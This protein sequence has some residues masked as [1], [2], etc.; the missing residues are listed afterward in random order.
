MQL[1]MFA[2]SRRRPALASF[3]LGGLLLAANVGAVPIQLGEVNM[4]R[5]SRG[6]NNVG[7]TAGEFFQYGAD[8]LGG[9]AGTTLGISYP[10]TPGITQNQFACSPLAV[11]ATFCSRSIGFNANRIAQPWLLRFERT[12]E[13]ALVVNGPSL[14]GTETAVPFPV[15]VTIS[16]SGLTP[17]LSWTIPDGFTP[18]AVRINIR[19]RESFL[20]SGTADVIHSIAV[21]ANSG[22]YT[23]PARLNSGQTLHFGG[24]YSFNIQLIDTRG[25]PAIFYATNNNSQ[26]LRRSSSFFNFTPLTADGP[27]NVF[28]PTVANGVYNFSITNVGPDSVT[29]I[30]PLVAIGCNYQIGAGDPNFASVLLPTGIGDNLFDLFLWN[31]TEFVDSGIDL[32]GGTQFFFGVGGV[33]RFSIRGIETGAGLDPNNVSAFVTG[34]T[35]VRGGNFTGTMTPIV[36]DVQL[37]EPPLVLLLAT[38]GLALLTSRRRV[39]PW[40][41][42]S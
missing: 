17:T 1:H 39:Q 4:L 25:D 3:A 10:G 27:P 13:S 28:L 40:R 19:D 34:L 42:R 30:D 14:A 35:F 2:A 15:N 23:I 7:Q 12:G 11:S 6:A 24:D 41:L 26:I 33:D 8:V 9:S 38:G 20:A 18:D 37:P 29:F 22:S 16:G 36:V 32:V 21:A 5:D 31:D